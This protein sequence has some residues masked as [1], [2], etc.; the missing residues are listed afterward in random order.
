MS[1]K[2]NKKYPYLIKGLKITQINQWWAT[3]ITFISM[4]KEHEYLTAIIDLYLRFILNWSLSSTIC[5]DWCAYFLQE[6]I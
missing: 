5:V 6:S 1:N 3:H 4:A 2:L